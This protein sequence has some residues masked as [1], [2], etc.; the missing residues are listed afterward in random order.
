MP[1]RAAVAGI[2]GWA[3]SSAFSP[4]DLWWVLPLAVAGITLACTGVSTPR[5]TLLGLI[6]G[7]AFFLSLL[8]WMRV[9]GTDAWI[10]LSVLQASFWALLG[11]G[12]AVVARLPGWPLWA[13]GVWVL[14]EALR[15]VVPWGGF[16][17]GRLAHA[18]VDSPLVGWV[19]VGGVTGLTAV[20]AA[21]GTLLAGLVTA[22][23]QRETG[24]AVSAV[25]LS[26][27]LVASGA[28]LGTVV[29]PPASAG[30]AVAAIVQGN[31]PRA[32]LDFQGQ[33]EAVLSNHI[34]ATRALADD[35]AAGRVPAPDLV[36]WPENSSDIDPF[37]DTT[38]QARIDEV[39]AEVSTPTLVGVLVG[40]EDGSQVENTAI[41]WDPE[42]GA[43]ERYIKRHPVPFGEYVPGRE[44]VAPLVG[45]LDRVPRDMRAGT[46]PGVLDVGPV[47]VGVVICFEIA[48]DAEVHDT[49]AEGGEVLVVQTNN[50]TY[51][52]TGQ[53]DQQ[54]AISRLRALEH[55]RDVLIASTSGISGIIHADGEVAAKSAEFTQEVFVRSVDLRDDLTW[56][57]RAGRVIAW[58]LAGVGVAG[59][60][61]GIIVR[62]RE[63]HGGANEHDR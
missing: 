4:V 33:R 63:R 22:T 42:T 49:V 57:T 62:R 7:L 8:D 18:L 9:V 16:P 38:V 46:E 50:A 41:V 44:L 58:L 36:L 51:G 53:P 17:W 1:V 14:V 27:L 13:G 25:V 34:E 52:R 20:A 26:A 45:R 40:T 39:V 61:G 47:T 56:A 31:V 43:G 48:Y 55:G 12:L 24:R 30:T 19:H 35:V 6:A 2:S 3:L 5:A 11:A 29:S 59:I 10:G 37:R 21:V 32:G 23:A 54:F 28:V 15:S 60:L